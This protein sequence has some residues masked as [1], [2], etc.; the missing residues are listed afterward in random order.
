MQW[1]KNLIFNHYFAD[2]EFETLEQSIN[3]SKKLLRS[4]VSRTWILKSSRA[5]ALNY[6]IR[7]SILLKTYY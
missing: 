3:L 7:L 5:E 4:S 2:K 1:A 6:G